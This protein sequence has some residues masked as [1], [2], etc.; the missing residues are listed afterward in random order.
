MCVCMCLDFRI[1]NPDLLTSSE[2]K[3]TEINEN[4]FEG[5][6]TLEFFTILCFVSSK[7]SIIKV[8]LSFES[9]R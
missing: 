9:V 4:G 2:R 5:H 6:K 1:Q 8:C 7:N 3:L